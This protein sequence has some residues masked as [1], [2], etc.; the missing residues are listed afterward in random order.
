MYADVDVEGETSLNMMVFSECMKK[1]DNLKRERRWSS[2][3][4]DVVLERVGRGL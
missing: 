1:R 2:P 3:A 4:R